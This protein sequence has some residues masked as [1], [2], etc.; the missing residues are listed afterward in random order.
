MTS[1]ACP[2]NASAVES[3]HAGQPQVGADQPQAVNA[4][5]PPIPKA[6]SSSP[7]NSSQSEL[8]DYH[9][10]P[11]AYFQGQQITAQRGPRNVADARIAVARTQSE[12]RKHLAALA[13]EAATDAPE[14]ATG[15]SEAA[16]VLQEEVD[17]AAFAASDD[18]KPASAH[19]AAV[20]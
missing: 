9:Q 12:E 1:W 7:S 10:T 2:T 4:V 3:S 20:A 19:G 13:K 11:A 15:A 16:A 6:A 14:A 5:P 17:L 18:V 8:C